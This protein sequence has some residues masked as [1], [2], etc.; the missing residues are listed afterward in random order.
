[1]HNK[2]NNSA[3]THTLLKEYKQQQ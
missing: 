3:T 1:L 2:Q